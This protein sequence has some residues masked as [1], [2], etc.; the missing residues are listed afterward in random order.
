[1]IRI[2]NGKWRMC[3]DFT[4]VNKACPKD[5]YPL[6]HIDQLVDA[7]AGHALVN[8]MD[9]YS[10]YNQIRMDP[11]KEDKTAFYTHN[12][13]YCYRVMPFGLK[14]AGSMYQKLVNHIFKHQLGRNVE[15]YVDDMLVKS[16]HIK[17]ITRSS[18]LPSVCSRLTSTSF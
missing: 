11:T 16:L 12:L 10:G 4:D 1:M 18:I 2:P 6:P 13:V 5:C 7:T 17:S 15:A 3:V 8:F 9:A 14:N